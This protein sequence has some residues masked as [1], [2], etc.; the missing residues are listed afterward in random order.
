MLFKSE[1]GQYGIVIYE[2][3]LQYGVVLDAGSSHTKLFI[4]KW[5]GEKLHETA[6]AKQVHYCTVIG[7]S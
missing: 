1:T 2:F 5:D 6:E 4:Y 7:M 3:L